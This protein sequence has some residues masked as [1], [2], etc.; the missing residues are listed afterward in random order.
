MMSDTNPKDQS[1]SLSTGKQ[2]KISNTSPILPD[3]PEAKKKSQG[4]KKVK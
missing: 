4:P 3:T 1:S 2:N